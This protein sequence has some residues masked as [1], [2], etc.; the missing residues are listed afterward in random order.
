LNAA[1]AAGFRKLIAS[2]FSRSHL[3]AVILAKFLPVRPWR[4]MTARG[5]MGL[6]QSE[7][8]TTKIRPLKGAGSDRMASASK[9]FDGYILE[10][11]RNRA[12]MAQLA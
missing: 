9:T 12:R 11:Q 2:K 1:I 6:T 4:K 8:M 3:L 10:L 7:R 5:I